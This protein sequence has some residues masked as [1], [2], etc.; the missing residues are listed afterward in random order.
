M[1]NTGRRSLISAREGVSRTMKSVELFAGA[2]GLGMGLHEAGFEPI[3]VVEWD[4]YCCDT[5]RENKTRRVSHVADWPL[6]EGDVRK[7]HFG[8]YEGKVDLVSGGPPC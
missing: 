2:G 3:E 1:R 4:R 7:V 6:T 8:R 5:I